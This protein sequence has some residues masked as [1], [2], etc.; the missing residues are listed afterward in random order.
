MAVY[1]APKAF[2][3]SFT[4]A[5]AEEL[6][7]T[8]LTATA[9]CPGPTRTNFGAAAGGRFKRVTGKVFHV[10]CRRSARLAI[11]R[12]APS[13]WWQIT[14]VAKQSPALAVRFVP[15]LIGPQDYQRL[16]AVPDPS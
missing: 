10:G 4:E 11:A 3:L 13:V 5:L 1:Y 6:A 7:G 16:N 14:G 15:R 9:V 12:S 2:V 8:G